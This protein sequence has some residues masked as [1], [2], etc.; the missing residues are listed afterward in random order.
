[1]PRKTS[2][3]SKLKTADD[4]CKILTGKR[5]NVI[6]ARGIEVFGED[7]FNKATQC[8][9]EDPE[10]LARKLPYIV[11]GINPD[12]PDIVLRASYKAMIRDCHPDTSKPDTDK[13]ARINVAYEAICKQRGIPK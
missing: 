3:K 4:I 6:L 5:M 1:M 12:A 11:L 9:A 10:E 13:A 2:L 7:V 8:P